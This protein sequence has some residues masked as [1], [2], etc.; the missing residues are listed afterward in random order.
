MATPDMNRTGG[1]EEERPKGLLYHYTSKSGAL[2]IIQ[3]QCAW[4]T[5]VRY[6]ND[7]SEFVLGWEKSWGK[8]Q[9]LI[10]Q[11]ALPNSAS[12]TKTFTRAR[13]AVSDDLSN[14]YVWC[15]TD[16]ESSATQHH[17]F[18]GDRLSQWRAYSGSGPGFSLGF[19]S[20]ELQQCSHT[21]L[22]MLFYLRKCIYD[23]DLQDQGFEKIAADHLEEFLSNWSHYASE[24]RD[25]ALSPSENIKKHGGFLFEAVGKMYLDFIDFGSF[26]KHPGFMEENEWRFA[27]IPENDADCS[28]REGRF[29]LTPYFPINLDLKR[30]PSPLKRIVVGPDR[31]KDEW[32]QTIKLML[33]KA[34]ITGVE[35]VPS[36]IPYR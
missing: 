17:G 14:Y 26:V 28:F 34:G 18:N 24:L 27:F 29:G 8:L 30:S 10:E 7:S 20:D 31:C 1:K 13:K 25:P 19:D 23:E 15:L 36:E 21:P 22:K 11:K 4:A 33:A 2:G 16:D 5:H 32:V 12:L 9:D 6:L 3:N 35:V